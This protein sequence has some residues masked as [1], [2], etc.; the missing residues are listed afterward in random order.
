MKKITITALLVSFFGLMANVSFA[1][2]IQVCLIPLAEIVSP[3]AEIF[4][5]SLQHMFVRNSDG[6][7]LNFEPEDPM[8]FLGAQAKI[9]NQNYGKA[10]CEVIFSGD[11][12]EYAK[13]W[14]DLVEA[15]QK[16]AQ[17][18]LYSVF[19]KNCQVVTQ[20]ILSDLSYSLPEGIK[21]KLDNQ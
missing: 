9:G 12:N 19:D 21:K 6:V 8:G 13:R 10:Q 7:G 15:Y 3:G 11:D 1:K 2:D 18:F 5:G 14:K 4:V 17:E 20:K 16:A